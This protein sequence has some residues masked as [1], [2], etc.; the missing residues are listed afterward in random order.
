MFRTIVFDALEG[1]RVA[2]ILCEPSRRR[3]ILPIPHCP[4]APLC[5]ASNRFALIFVRPTKTDVLDPSVKARTAQ[6]LCNDGG[7]K[8]AANNRFISR[9]TTAIR[10][11]MLNSIP[12]PL[13]LCNPSHPKDVRKKQNISRAIRARQRTARRRVGTRRGRTKYKQVGSLS[14][15]PFLLHFRSSQ[16]TVMNVSRSTSKRNTM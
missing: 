15:K 11:W 7:T 16:I 9:T 12:T 2:Y 6:N 10:S 4:A 1:K 3:S 13:S 8:P 5:A 14:K